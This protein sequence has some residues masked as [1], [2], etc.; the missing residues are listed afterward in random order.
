MPAVR[1]LLSRYRVVVLA[2][3]VSA[4]VHAAVLIGIPK[5]IAALEQAEVVYAATLQEAA[6]VADFSTAAVNVPA[7]IAPARARRARSQQAAAPQLGAAPEVLA[8]APPPPPDLMRPLETP[9]PEEPERL[10]LAEPSSA[11]LNSH[12]PDL[13][14]VEALPASLSISYRLTSAFADGHA[15]YHWNREGDKY[16]IT[17]EAEAEGFFALFLEGRIQ[18]ESTGTVGRNGLKPDRYLE[19]RPPNVREGLEFDWPAGK[20]TMMR[21]DSTKSAPLAENTVDWLSM[22][23]QLAHMPPRGETMAMQVYTQRRMHRY[24]LAILGVEQID[25]PLGKV[26]ALH[27]RHVDEKDKNEVVDV[28]LGLDQHY[29]PVKLRFPVAKNRL[30]VEQVATRVSAR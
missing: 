23:F 15:V 30:V 10:A 25:I 29:L 27:L 14:P 1:Q 22:I 2:L 13:F 21:G 18:Q 3:A 5:R 24:R 17:G 8:A 26:R 19:Q 7:P 12:E 9:V 6:P 16:R 28:W 11:P 20:V 4:V